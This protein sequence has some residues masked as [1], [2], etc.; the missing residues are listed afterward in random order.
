MTNGKD[1]LIFSAVPRF[2]QYILDNHFEEYL[3]KEIA[4]ARSME[5]P[6]W[7]KY[8]DVAA[9]DLAK[10][11]RAYFTSFLQALATNTVHENLQVNIENYKQ[12]LLKGV[13]RDLITPEDFILT[14]AARKKALLSFVC[15]YSSSSDEIVKIIDEIDMILCHYSVAATDAYVELITKNAE[16][17]RSIKDKLFTTS[18]GFY[19]IYDLHQ[20]KQVLISERLFDSLGYERFE[21]AG[22]SQFF[23]HIMHPDDLENAVSYFASLKSMKEGEVRFFE[24][25]MRDSK[26]EYQWMRNYESVYKWNADKTPAQLLGVALDITRERFFTEEIRSK[27]EALSEAQSL[28]HMGAY[29]W[30][31]KNNV[32][33]NFSG[34]LDSLGIS[35]GR[36]FSEVMDKVHPSD[37]KEVLKKFD[38][39]LQGKYDF[40]CEY[41]CIINNRER[42]LWSRGR[43]SVDNN[44]PRYFK[45]TVMDVTDR[46]HMVRKLQRSEQL[47]KQA[48]ALNKIG[49][50]SWH[51]D[52]GRIQWSDE[53]FKIFGLAPQSEKMDYER[54]LE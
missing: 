26:G 23:K 41:R 46:H 31:L 42:I 7:K 25:R 27:E 47:Y 40:E 5:I 4:I 50:W 8:R 36:T 3:Y 28:A 51:I 20:D 21:Y 45:A 34:S 13:T 19:Y 49:N 43:V 11:S 53:L 14:H 12:D 44:E 6:L 2:A 18:P 17:E 10:N 30:D 37:R 54:F 52:T 33:L 9:E 1:H 24:Y 32:L 22:N 29:T 39:A 16:E 38:R 35:E 15:H 48:Q